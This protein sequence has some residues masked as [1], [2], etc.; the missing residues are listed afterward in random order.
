MRQ[1][2]PLLRDLPVEVG[3]LAS[4][5]FFVALGFGIVIPSIPIFAESF[6]VSALAASAVVSAFALMRFVSS[7]FAGSLVNRLGERRVLAS[8]LIIVA[9]SSFLAGLS[10][11]YAQLIV[12]RAAGG[13]GSAMFTVSA[14]ALLLR[15]VEARQRGRAS[16]AW[17]GGFLFGGVAGPAIGGLVLAWSIRAPFFFYAGTLTIATFVALYFLHPKRIARLE[18]QVEEQETPGEPN[19]TG[20][21]ELKTALR[22]GAYRAALG[23]NLMTGLA[24]FGL[25][26]A[27]VPLFVI[28]GLHAGPGLSGAAFLVAAGAQAVLLL[29]AGRITDTRGR[30]PAML[31]GTLATLLGLIGLVIDDQLTSSTVFFVAMAILGIG[32]AFLGSAPSAVVGDVMGGRKGGI[33]IATY[34]MV[35]DLGAVVGPLLGGLLLDLYGFDW[36]FAA[37][38]AVS[39]IAL[40]LVVLMPETLR[41]V[42]ATA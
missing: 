18:E 28:E 39:V 13:V 10:Q 27:L 33:V 16:A 34:Q 31:I 14:L 22:S 36:A 21:P 24:T 9:A 38:A 15:T 26:S 17:Q 4:I 40:V 11:T 29:P 23:V 5:A 35:S 42:P 37:G 30:K 3:V 8:G 20:W 12:L 32:T 19:V 6:G 41:K 25:R 7:P 2:V 1:R